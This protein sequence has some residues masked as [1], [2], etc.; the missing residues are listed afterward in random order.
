MTIANF[1]PCSGVM[2]RAYDGYHLRKKLPTRDVGQD[3]GVTPA[4][5]EN[6]IMSISRKIA[7]LLF[8]A[9]LLAVAPGLALAQSTTLDQTPL[10]S[11]ETNCNSEFLLQSYNVTGGTVYYGVARPPGCKSSWVGVGQTFVPS[12]A[13]GMTRYLRLTDAKS[14]LG[15]P[16]TAS[17]GTPSGTV[18]VSRSAG[19]SLQ[20]LGEAT[21][22]NAKT[23]NALFEFDLPDSYVANA[24]VAITVNCATNNTT[25]V[26][27]ASTTMTVNAYT[28]VN[29][30]ETALT[31]SAA[32]QIPGAA[33]DLVFTLTGTGL[34]PGAHISIEL[35]MLVTTTSGGTAHGIINSVKYGA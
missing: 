26:T 1:A 9:A 8:G 22:A 18:G 3:S 33:T 28:E 31:V 10:P 27:A 32:Q 12:S 7:S 30:A 19:T 21:S 16:L 6:R 29:G 23:D 5:K 17:A 20:L 24:N 25:D 11:T 13:G 34:V 2:Q 14:D 35:V 15:V 4:K